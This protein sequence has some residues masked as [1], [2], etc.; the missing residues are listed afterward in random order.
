MGAAW[1]QSHISAV[2]GRLITHAAFYKYWTV[3]IPVGDVFIAAGGVVQLWGGVSAVFQ[4]VIWQ[5]CEQLLQLQKAAHGCE[6]AR[7]LRNC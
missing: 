4:H 1:Q 2:Y 6:S 3:N 5:V 7:L